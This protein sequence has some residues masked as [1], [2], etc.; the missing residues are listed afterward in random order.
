MQ[1]KSYRYRHTA[2]GIVITQYVPE[3]E[4]TS[5]QIPAVLEGSPVTEIGEEAFAENGDR[6]SVV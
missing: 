4:E 2:G 6:K 5:V 1:W 3:T